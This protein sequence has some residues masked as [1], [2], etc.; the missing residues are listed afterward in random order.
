MVFPATVSLNG[1]Y[2]NNVFLRHPRNGT[3]IPKVNLRVTLGHR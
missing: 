1:E 3:S 2:M